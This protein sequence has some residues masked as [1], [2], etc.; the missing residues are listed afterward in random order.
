MDFAYGIIFLDTKPVGAQ[1]QVHSKTLECQNRHT[2]SGGEV[3]HLRGLL[4]ELGVLEDIRCRHLG[5]LGPSFYHLLVLGL[6]VE[7]FSIGFGVIVLMLRGVS[8][9]IKVAVVVRHVVERDTAVGC[10]CW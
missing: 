5:E 9:I 4:I 7:M 10:E 6:L 1:S 3:Q 8:M 2:P